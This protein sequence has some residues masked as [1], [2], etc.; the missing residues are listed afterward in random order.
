MFQINGNLEIILNHTT[1]YSF[2]EEF[3]W[4]T[5]LKNCIRTLNSLPLCTF[6]E[7]LKYDFIFDNFFKECFCFI[8]FTKMEF[9][10]YNFFCFFFYLNLL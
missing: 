10:K 7:Q 4:G 8:C 1:S 6:K 2:G 9:K 3:W 5:D